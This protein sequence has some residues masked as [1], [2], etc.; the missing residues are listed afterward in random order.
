MA[1]S[2]KWLPIPG[3]EQRYEVS[4][5][6]RIRSLITADSRGQKR[7]P[8]L[9]AQS[10]YVSKTGRTLRTFCT[11]MKADGTR[12]TMPT[13]RAVMLAFVGE[14]PDGM[15]ICHNDGDPTNNRLTNLRYDTHKGNEADKLAHGTHKRGE[16]NV[17]AKLTQEQAQNIKDLKTVKRGEL[18]KLAKEYNVSLVTVSAVRHGRQWGWL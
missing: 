11:L 16:K 5:A 2:E 9:L 10:K 1:N 8:G 3:Y 15:V 12:N 4:D 14:R 18:T 17:K 7:T 13:H 6:G